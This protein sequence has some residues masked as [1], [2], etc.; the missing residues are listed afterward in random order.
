MEDEKDP[1]AHL[2]KW[3][4]ET[5]KVETLD[6]K[7]NV[8]MYQINNVS[9]LDDNQLI[10]IITEWMN[11]E[12]HTLIVG[13]NELT[14]G[15][16]T[17][18]SRKK[19]HRRINRR[20][21]EVF[22]FGLKHVF[23]RYANESRLRLLGVTSMIIAVMEY[24]K[25]SGRSPVNPT[26]SLI[27]WGSMCTKGGYTDKEI[28]RAVYLIHTIGQGRSLPSTLPSN[29]DT[30]I[31]G[32]GGY[33]AVCIPTLE[34]DDLITQ[35]PNDDSI[36]MVTKL[37][38]NKEAFDKTIAD[39]K[40]VA[41]LFQNQNYLVTPHT[42]RTKQN[43]PKRLQYILN[44]TLPT[45][46]TFAVK[47]RDFGK[48][49]TVLS[50]KKDEINAFYACPFGTILRE[51]AK[52][53]AQLA[54]LTRSQYIHGDVRSA[55][56]MWD[57]RTKTMHLI[58]FDWLHT[59]EDFAVEYYDYMGFFSN[60]PETL[61]LDPSKTSNWAEGNFQMNSFYF[62]RAYSHV[63]DEDT[64][65]ALVKEANQ[66]NGPIMDQEMKAQKNAEPSLTEM[67]SAMRALIHES[68]PSFDS[69]GFAISILN[70]FAIIYP[71]ILTILP[72]NSNKYNEFFQAMKVNLKQYSEPMLHLICGTLLQLRDILIGM[73]ELTLPNRIPAIEGSEQ[74]M[75]LY[76][77][78]L[79]QEEIIQKTVSGGQRHKSTRRR[80]STRRR[81]S[82][83]RRMSKKKRSTRRR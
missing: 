51:I 36:H 34:N 31:L 18:E 17:E 40:K 16:S 22:L 24:L 19:D 82:T 48:D 43:L 69:F 42:I 37:F 12:L 49:L 8:H 55:N 23:R 7:N 61:W 75:A 1:L 44:N 50:K 76:K 81:K 64:L 33:G 74:I 70:L 27:R 52:C 39:S 66:I 30:C 60:P 79:E 45:E 53:S 38:Y 63:K 5:F 72:A 41:T 62:K 4:K 29:S 13:D 28:R 83:R 6:P 25:E 46:N 9:H 14:R 73:C 56:I 77:T 58:D 71:E 68:F 15:N 20:A 35:G 59:Y 26:F 2:P 21:K 57:N 10:A 54:N 65:V 78:Y 47:M 11:D 32:R 80:M 67:G 3:A